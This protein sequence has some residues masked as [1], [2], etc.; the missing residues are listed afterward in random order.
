MVKCLLSRQ[1]TKPLKGYKMNPD[2]TPL[3]LTTDLLTRADIQVENLFSTMWQ[4]LG[5]RV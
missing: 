3:F 4:R 1:N 5:F 2:T